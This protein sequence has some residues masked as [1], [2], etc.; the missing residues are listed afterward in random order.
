M[1]TDSLTRRLKTMVPRAVS[2]SVVLILPA[3]VCATYFE[4]AAT[5][6]DDAQAWL[7]G[8]LRSSS[9]RGDW[10]G[11]LDA[12]PAAIDEMVSITLHLVP[13]VGLSALEER[14]Y[15]VSGVL[16]LHRWCDRVHA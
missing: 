11:C 2:F 12:G 9:P 1:R 3:L 15:A 6:P 14:L 13:S 5:A 8:H 4:P 7:A 10:L 16:A